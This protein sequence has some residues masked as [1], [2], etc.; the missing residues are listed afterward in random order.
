MITVLEELC[1]RKFLQ[2]EEVEFSCNERGECSGVW[3]AERESILRSQL[4]RAKTN[5]RSMSKADL[6]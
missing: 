1:Q 4:L 5:G 3:K 2:G 6:E